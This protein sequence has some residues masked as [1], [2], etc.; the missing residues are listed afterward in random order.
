[1]K[2]RLKMP[3]RLFAGLFL[4]SA[5]SLMSPA[6]SACGKGDCSVAGAC[7]KAGK[8][9]PRLAA[10]KDGFAALRKD[11]SAMEKGIP[12]ARMAQFMKA[13]RAH[14][15][16][17]IEEHRTTM[18]DC[19]VAQTAMEDGCPYARRIESAFKA[20]EKDEAALRKG[21]PRGDQAA[22]LKAHE[23]NL[24]RLLNARAECTMPCPAKGSVRA[25]E[26]V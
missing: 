3:R 21:L 18:K 16:K 13:H 25:G 10:K 26:K 11:L 14:L 15:E 22:F 8:T 4:L 7:V 2:R 6:L 12:Q 1:M 5:L 19:P 9:C 17:V 24:K 23:A 20:L